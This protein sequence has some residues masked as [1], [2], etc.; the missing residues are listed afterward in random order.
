MS[1]KT[2]AINTDVHN[3]EKIDLYRKINIPCQVIHVIR[4]M[5]SFSKAET[6]ILKIELNSDGTYWNLI[7][8]KINMRN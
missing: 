8:K 4:F 5:I 6:M 1:N 7:I 3:Y 2:Y